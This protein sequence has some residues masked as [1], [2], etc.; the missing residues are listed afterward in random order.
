MGVR[1][2]RE[3]LAAISRRYLNSYFDATGVCQEAAGIA[4]QHSI[5][6]KHNRSKPDDLS[7]TGSLAT[8]HILC[9]SN[10]KNS[11][12]VT[13]LRMKCGSEASRRM[14]PTLKLLAGL[15]CSSCLVL[16]PSSQ[17]ILLA[18]NSVLAKF[19]ELWAPPEGFE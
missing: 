13:G 16:I 6:R 12:V 9:T 15:G 4:S 8:S 2:W 14:G 10:R 11:F 7:D 3:R 19:G 1:R 17:E 18:L 5:A